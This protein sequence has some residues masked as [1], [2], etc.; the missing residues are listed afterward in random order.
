M[1]T[2]WTA[3]ADRP[4]TGT[5]SPATAG[6]EDRPTGHSASGR[7]VRRL[8]SQN[9]RICS[10]EFHQH[11]KIKRGR[12]AARCA[13]TVG[14]STTLC[15]H[16]QARMHR[17]AAPCVPATPSLAWERPGSAVARA[18]PRSGPAVVPAYLIAAMT[19]LF[20]AGG[21]HDQSSWIGGRDAGTRE[22][23]TGQTSFARLAD[24]GH[25]VADHELHA[26]R[27][28]AWGH[29][30]LPLCASLLPAD[31]SCRP[32]AAG[33]SDAAGARHAAGDRRGWLPGR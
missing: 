32:Q 23:P 4:C 29:R 18:A 27:P 10:R 26:L 11:Q 30:R 21:M 9:T 5:I 31:R 3:L 14:E 19:G 6:A 22:P 17:G 16:R 7:Q 2:R 12:S 1:Y 15:D 20:G 25:K 24:A 8:P 33:L 13:A 28:V